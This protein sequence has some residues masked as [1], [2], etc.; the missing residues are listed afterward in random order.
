MHDVSVPATAAPTSVTPLAACTEVTRF[1]GSFAALRGVTFDLPSAQLWGLFGPNGAGKS[2]LLRIL[3][4]VLR[5]TSGTV[6]VAGHPVPSQQSRQMTG[7]LSHECFLHPVLTVAENLRYYAMLYDLPGP[8][9]AVHE[10]LTLVRGEHLADWRVGEMSQGMR[11]KAALARAMLH[12]P[13]L[14]LLDEPFASLDRNT[15]ADL[16][17]TLKAL[18]DRGLSLVVSTHT[19][20]LIADFA[21]AAITLDRGKVVSR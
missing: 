20:A 3:A 11:Q 1:F 7:L 2:T 15:V 10:A 8:S 5:P 14:L 6:T 12:S 13:R 9:R 16:R 17:V 4:G 19:E 21:D 18:R